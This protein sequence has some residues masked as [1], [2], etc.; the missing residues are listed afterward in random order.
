LRGSIQS[1]LKKGKKEGEVQREIINSRDRLK[2]KER[3][4]MRG[5]G[6]MSDVVG[7]RRT[8]EVEEGGVVAPTPL[9]KREENGRIT[10]E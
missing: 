9:K 7:E 6:P 1:R 2:K 3:G 5:R 10:R 8:G 4:E